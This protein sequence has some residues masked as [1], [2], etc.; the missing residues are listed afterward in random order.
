MNE[1]HLQDALLTI[2]NSESLKPFIEFLQE[3]RERCRNALETQPN[4]EL[5]KTLQGEAQ[6][7]KSILEAIEDAQ[8]V[9]KRRRT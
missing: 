7:F 8:D 6:A 2:R 5:L 9:V 4:V 3:N 1:K